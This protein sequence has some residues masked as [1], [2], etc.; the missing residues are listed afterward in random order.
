MRKFISLPGIEPWFLGRLAH[1]VI[2]IPTEPFR[3]QSRLIAL[4]LLLCHA[5]S[6]SLSYFYTPF[7]I[8]CFILVPLLLFAFLIHFHCLFFC[9]SFPQFYF[10]SASFISLYHS[11]HFT[12]TCP[13]FLSCY[14]FYKLHCTVKT[15]PAI[16]PLNIKWTQYSNIHFSQTDYHFIWPGDM[17]NYSA[18]FHF[19]HMYSASFDKVSNSFLCALWGQVMLWVTELTLVTGSNSLFVCLFVSICSSV[20][21]HAEDVPEGGLWQWDCDPQMSARH[22]HLRPGCSVREFCTLEGSVPAAAVVTWTARTSA[23]RHL[24]LAQRTPGQYDLI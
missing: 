21:R 3:P 4:Y 14:P 7:L 19:V 12:L 17:L 23:Q 10:F 24:P 5:Y 8:P 1:S 9:V 20:V 13:V 15:S 11:V 16:P 6:C 18:V 2:I 22:Q